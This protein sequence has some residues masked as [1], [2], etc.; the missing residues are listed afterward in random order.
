MDKAIQELIDYRAIEQLMIRYAERIDANDPEGAA[1]CFTEDGIGNY[2]KLYKGREAIAGVLTMILDLFSVTSHHLTNSNI[3]LKGDEATGMAYVYAFHRM[4][5]NNEPLHYWGRWIDRFK[6]TD[7]GWLIAE[8]Q[9][10]G[11]GA[12]ETEKTLS[13]GNSIPFTYADH[14]GRLKR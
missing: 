10:V 1:A 8:R 13:D 11:I 4:A 9:V 5:A 7:E 6:R 2:W 14:P 12:I 3:T